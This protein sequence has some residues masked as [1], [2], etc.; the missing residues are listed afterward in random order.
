VTEQ[1]VPE[2]GAVLATDVPS[3]VALASRW[4]DICKT[5]HGKECNEGLGK[6]NFLPTRLID[7]R[8]GSHA[9]PRL[10]IT[11]SSLDGE[12]KY[13]TLSHCWGAIEIKQ[14]KTQDLEA[15]KEGIEFSTLSKTFQDA[16]QIT[17]GLGI[18]YI[19][20]DSLCIIQDCQSDWFKESGL[21]GDI[22]ANSYCNIAATAAKDGTVG[23]I[24][25]R[26]PILAHPL[27]V[28]TTWTDGEPTTYCL[29]DCNMWTREVDDAPLNQRAWV[30]QE[31]FLSP[32]NLSFGANRLF[33]ECE[34]KRACETFPG[35]LP[36]SVT[37]ASFKVSAPAVLN[38][39]YPSR[40]KKEKKEE[41]KDPN[42]PDHAA[43]KA[44]LLMMTGAQLNIPRAGGFA[45]LFNSED[46]RLTL[47]NLIRWGE[48]FAKCL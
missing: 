6:R 31:R 25:K 38:K 33:W 20:I 29:I 34:G 35:R 21:M 40:Q 44:W 7:V 13:T 32:R 36:Y 43:I 4:I 24:Y 37:G 3:S 10:H 16:I 19:W 15:M 45:G 5:S 1:L 17:R 12:A 8:C 27:H 26:D 42:E 11:N 47:S 18:P 41:K 2:K 14:L 46:M 23:C 22:Y 9:N 48:G 30:F 28:Q 39:T